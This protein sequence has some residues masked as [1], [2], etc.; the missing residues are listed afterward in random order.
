MPIWFRVRVLH[1]LRP[2]TACVS[3]FLPP[4]PLCPSISRSVLETMESSPLSPRVDSPPS[5]LVTASR[6]GEGSSS[7]KAAMP[8]NA[9]DDVSDLSDVES[10]SPTPNGVI[11]APKATLNVRRQ[12]WI[13][14]VSV[15]HINSSFNPQSRSDL[16]L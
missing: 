1:T 7:S 11:V 4:C 2:H 13:H 5:S 3:S 9:F 10:R 8:A 6:A 15:D 12:A 14:S 16:L